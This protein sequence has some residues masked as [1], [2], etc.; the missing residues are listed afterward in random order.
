MAKITIEIDDDTFQKAIIQKYLDDRWKDYRLLKEQEDK[1]QQI[2]LSD[3]N[4]KKGT[5]A[6]PVL[7]DDKKQNASANWEKHLRKMDRKLEKAEHRGRKKKPKQKIGRPKKK[8]LSDDNDVMVPSEIT[9]PKQR[10][11]W[12]SLQPKNKEPV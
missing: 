4:K 9:N 5:V 1:L 2:H 12:K 11:L 3:D 10:E 7:S 6:V 8:V